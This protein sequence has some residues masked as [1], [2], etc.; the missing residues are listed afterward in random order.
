MHVISIP[1]NV[2]EQLREYSHIHRMTKQAVTVEAFRVFFETKEFKDV[3][4]NQNL[5]K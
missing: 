4:P 3:Q 2:Y 5:Q 1:D